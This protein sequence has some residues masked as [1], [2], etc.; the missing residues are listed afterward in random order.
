MLVFSGAG[1]PP[2]IFRP[3]TKNFLG[4]CPP[5]LRVWM[6]GFPLISRLGSGTGYWQGNEVQ[7]NLSNQHWREEWGDYM[8]VFQLIF[9]F[10]K[11]LFFLCLNSLA[12]ITIPKNN[13]KIKINWNK[14]LTTCAYTT[15]YESLVF[16][17]SVI[18]GIVAFYHKSLRFFFYQASRVL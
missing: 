15:Q 12:Y 18:Q 16:S 1:E 9:Y 10:S 14:E 6:T 13:G 11:F 8:C 5:R 7:A 4:G 3:N 2:F 17:R